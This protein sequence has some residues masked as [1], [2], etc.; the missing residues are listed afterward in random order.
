MNQSN[1]FSKYIFPCQRWLGLSTEESQTS[2]TLV[3]IPHELIQGRVSSQEPTAV[4][5]TLALELL[6]LVTRY[7]IH[8]FT[9]TKSGAGTNADVFIRLHGDN[10]S[11]ETLWLRHSQTNKDPFESGR[12]DTFEVE[13]KYLGNLGKITLV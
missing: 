6:S 7:T 3:P 13:A 1:F 10:D 2:W 11:S 5:E 4:R 9:G 8:V 12:C